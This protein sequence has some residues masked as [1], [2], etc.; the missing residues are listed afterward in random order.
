MPWRRTNGQRAPKE[1]T[2]RASM[3]ISASDPDPGVEL[4]PDGIGAYAAP[5]TR[6]ACRIRAF[7]RGRGDPGPH[8][9]GKKTVTAIP[10]N[11][12]FLLRRFLHSIRAD[13]STSR[14]WEPEV[15]ENGDLATV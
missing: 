12:L 15:A 9:C 4:H 1:L 10:H 6:T 3:S 14:S 8:Q 2:R 11:K 7:L 5:E 13:I